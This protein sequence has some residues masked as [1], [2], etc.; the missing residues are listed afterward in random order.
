MGPSSRKFQPIQT[1]QLR[2]SKQWGDIGR[3]KRSMLISSNEEG[4][5]WAANANETNL[6]RRLIRRPRNDRE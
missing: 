1:S 3:I 2:F 6:K 4:R 5:K